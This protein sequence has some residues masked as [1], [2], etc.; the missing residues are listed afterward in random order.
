MKYQSYLDFRSVI[1]VLTAFRV[2]TAPSLNKIASYD[3][4]L[5][6]IEVL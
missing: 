6:I 5:K 3:F 1:H 4:K 2:K